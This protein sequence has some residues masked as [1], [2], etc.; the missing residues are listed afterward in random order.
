MQR[1]LDNEI[2]VAVVAVAILAFALIAALLLS[3]SSPT[4]SPTLVPTMTTPTAVTQSNT[5]DAAPTVTVPTQQTSQVQLVIETVTSSPTITNM[6]ETIRSATATLTVTREPTNTAIPTS[7]VTSTV[8]PT[9]TATQTI[10]PTH[11]LTQ[12]ATVTTTPTP[13]QTLTP[14]LI[15]TATET[16]TPIVI[17]RDAR[18]PVLLPTI[19]SVDAIPT[20]PATCERPMTWETVTISDSVT[21]YEL[22]A[23]TGVSLDE[24]LHVNC[25]S[26]TDFVRSGTELFVPQAPTETLGNLPYAAVDSDVSP[27]GCN[28]PDTRITFPNSQRQLS[29]IVTVFG[30]AQ[31]YNFAYYVVDVR[32]DFAVTYER[33]NK[34]AQEVNDGILALMNTEFFGG[35]VYWIRLS[36][37]D[38]RG[39]I[40]PRAICEIP[41]IFE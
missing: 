29:G 5:I 34:S 3:D 25:L 23:A 8:T 6:P 11:T 9:I 39:E 14:T 7:A 36:L 38:E 1:N 35:G 28:S 13:T 17:T 20:Q 37:V 32:P 2:V 30:T 33:V 18:T 10:T 27:I 19:E 21:L 22:A 16:H 4:E 15:P 26:H 12:T 41:V 31:R 24:L 40:P